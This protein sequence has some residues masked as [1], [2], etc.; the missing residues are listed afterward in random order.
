MSHLQ[1]AVQRVPELGRKLDFF[2]G[3]GSGSEHNIARSRDLLRQLERIG[4]HDTPAHRQYLEEVL[5][6]TLNDPT[7][8][9]V[10]QESGRVLRQTLRAGPD[11]F[12]LME[13]V[14]QGNQLIAL[15]LKQG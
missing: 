15:Y 12:V 1:R 2:F 9:L 4:L 6:K 3:K 10:V 7:N 5:T 11:G 14:W 8:I 13:T